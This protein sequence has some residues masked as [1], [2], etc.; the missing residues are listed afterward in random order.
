MAAEAMLIF[1]EVPI[2]GIQLELVSATNMKTYE[3]FTHN[4]N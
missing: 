1:Y 2:R 3:M 4:P